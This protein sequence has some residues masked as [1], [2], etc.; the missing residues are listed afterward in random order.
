MNRASNTAIL[1]AL[2]LVAIVWGV[3]GI[4]LSCLSRFSAVAFWMAD[5]VQWVVLP[6]AILVFLARRHAV[7]P[8]NYGFDPAQLRVSACLWGLVAGATFYAAFFWVRDF[9]FMRLG[10]PTGFFALEDVF[11]GGVMGTVV[12]IYSAL[13]AGL[14]ESIFFIGLPW[15]LWSRLGQ[16]GTFSFALLCSLVFAA[17]H[18][19]QGP[20]V[21]AGALA[22]NLVACAWYF[23]LRSLW[24][25]AIGHALVDLIAFN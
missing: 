12:W 22:F 4:Y 6:A 8:A 18:W 17:V 21:V 3:N 20:H 14:I 24:P 13:S 5:L 23:R 1:V 19:E 16:S 10:A 2:L 15:L 11:P 25:V 9:T 7:F